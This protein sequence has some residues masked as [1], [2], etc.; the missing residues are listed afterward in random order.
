V[1]P[2]LLKITFAG[3]DHYVRQVNV[4]AE[5]TR[6]ALLQRGVD[7]KWH[8]AVKVA[9]DTLSFLASSSVQ[10]TTW[11]VCE[12]PGHSNGWN[13]AGSD[14]PYS[15]WVP[16]RATDTDR[17]AVAWDESFTTPKLR[18]LADS[19][20]KLPSTYVVEGNP[21]PRMPMV[22]KNVCPGEGCSFGEWLTCDTLRVFTAAGDNPKTAFVLRRGDRFTALTGDV[23][24][25]Q[26]GKVAFTRNVRVSDEGMNYFFTPADT[27]YPLLYGG[28]G[29]GTWYFRGKESGGFFFFGNADQESTDIPVVAGVSGYVLLRPIN[30]AWWVKVRAKNGQEGWLRPG[31]SIYG[32]SPHYEEMPAACPSK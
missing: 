6:V 1:R 15:A 18:Q 14:N 21:E 13:G 16:V 29:G 23:H 10:D 9:R 11:T 31:G 7:G 22:Y 8:G 17:M 28:E 4:V 27:L 25:K 19:V 30:S 20:S 5:I 26:A 12:K 2:R 32:M 3:N 24:I